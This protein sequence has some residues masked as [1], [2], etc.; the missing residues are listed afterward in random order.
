MTRN[1]T[2]A[3]EQLEGEILNDS[4]ESLWNI[5][6]QCFIPTQRF[7]TNIKSLKN[8]FK[9]ISVLF[10]LLLTTFLLKP[11]VALAGGFNQTCSNMKINGNKTSLYLSATCLKINGQK[12]NSRLEISKYIGYHNHELVWAPREG[13]FLKS[14]GNVK[15]H[16]DGKLQATCEIYT[17]GPILISIIDLKAHI[18]NQDGVLTPD[19]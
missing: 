10:F 4:A 3:L 12:A 6:P 18:S 15:Y 2:I 11:D 16:A 1:T 5:K 9:I 7:F 8:T 17:T 13:G 19:F 14:C